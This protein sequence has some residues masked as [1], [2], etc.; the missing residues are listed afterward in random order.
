MK[1]LDKY[2]ALID[3]YSFRRVN[4][5]QLIIIIFFICFCSNIFHI[6]LDHFAKHKLVLNVVEIDAR[7]P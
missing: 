7:S 2:L 5:A 6:G 3:L 4:Q 1:Y